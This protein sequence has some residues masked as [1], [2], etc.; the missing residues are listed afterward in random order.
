MGGVFLGPR[1]EALGARVLGARLRVLTGAE[2]AERRLWLLGVRR[3]EGRSSLLL[4]RS[5]TAV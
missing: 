1:V 5:A 4:L 2:G 3:W